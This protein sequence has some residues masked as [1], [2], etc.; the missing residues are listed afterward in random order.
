M[1]SAGSRPWGPLT[2]EVPNGTGRARDEAGGVPAGSGGRSPSGRGRAEGHE[3]RAVHGRQ[4]EFE[5]GGQE[6]GGRLGD[7]AG[8]HLAMGEGDHDAIGFV[9]VMAFVAE[10][11]EDGQD[12]G[13]VEEHDDAK[14]EGGEERLAPG[15]LLGET[16]HLQFVCILV[17]DP[18]WGKG[19]L[20]GFPWHTASPCPR[21]ARAF[22]FPRRPA[23]LRS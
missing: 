13:G 4:R 3:L 2:R 8:V 22:R 20:L 15:P 11:V 1:G 10:V 14:E 12:G 6:A 5:S 9:A 7:G 23:S 19:F 17:A 16:A 21:M 18:R